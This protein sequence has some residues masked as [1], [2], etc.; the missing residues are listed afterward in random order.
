MAKDSSGALH[1]ST[2]GESSSA[3]RMEVDYF[4]TTLEECQAQLCSLQLFLSP[5]ASIANGKMGGK[6]EGDVLH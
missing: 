3:I 2:M 1:L 5:S 6:M 4:D